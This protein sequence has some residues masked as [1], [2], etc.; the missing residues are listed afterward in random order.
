[1]SIQQV[2]MSL[3]LDPDGGATPETPP[4]V[5]VEVTIQRPGRRIHG[6]WH[7]SHET[8]WHGGE[9]IADAWGNALAHINFATAQH[10][11]PEGGPP[12]TPGAG[13]VEETEEARA[14]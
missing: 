9:T 12:G 5:G 14:A 4:R 13:V 2:R 1:M 6:V 10:T 3:A 7:P 8:T 11:A